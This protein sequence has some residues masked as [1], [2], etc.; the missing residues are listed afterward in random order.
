MSFINKVVLVSGAGSGIGKAISLHFAKLSARLSLIDKDSE[1]L[2]KTAVECERLSRAKV[3]ITV[4]DLREDEDVKKAVHN[5]KH[6]FGRIDIVINCAG[7]YKPGHILQPDLIEVFDEVMAT[8][9]RSVVCITNY[10]TSALTE[11]KGCIINISSATCVLGAFKSI[12]YISSVAA[13]NHFTASVALDLAAQGIR[14]NS[15]SPGVVKTNIMKNAGFDEKVSDTFWNEV[16]SAPM[17]RIVKSEDIA[18]LAAFLASDK[19][20]AMTG[21]IYSIDAG[22]ALI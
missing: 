15:I 9:L 22:L 7:I 2:K 16:S 8:N 3:L 6:S 13:L 5:T 21:G 11:T 20:R 1:N 17:I 19:A 10:V 4:A 14:V 18:E 12:P